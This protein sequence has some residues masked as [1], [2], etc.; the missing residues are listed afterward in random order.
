LQR[1]REPHEHAPTLVEYRT[2]QG[3]LSPPEA[4]IRWPRPLC[5]QRGQL[6]IRVQLPL[7]P[8]GSSDQRSNCEYSPVPAKRPPGQRSKRLDGTYPPPVLG[9]LKTRARIAGDARPALVEN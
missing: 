7:L 9:S 3:E 5:S 6:M 2:Y 1:T 4:A 8:A